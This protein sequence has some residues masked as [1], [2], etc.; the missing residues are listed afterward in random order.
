MAAGLAQ[1]ATESLLSLW[2][3]LSAEQLTGLVE[4]VQ[5]YIALHLYEAQSIDPEVEAA[6][7]L[8]GLLSKASRE[9]LPVPA[10]CLPP[11]LSSLSPCAS[12]PS[13]PGPLATQ[14]NERSGAIPF[15]L[16]YN[17]AVNSDDFNIV[18]D[19]R[20]WKSSTGHFSFCKYSFI[21]DTASK[22]RIL[23][24]PLPRCRPRLPRNATL[25]RLCCQQLENDKQMYNEFQDA[26]L[27]SWLFNATYPFLLLSVRRSPYLV[28]DTL[29]QVESASIAGSLKKPLKVQ[30]IGEEGVDEGGVTKEFFQ[31]LLRELFDPSYGMF[32]YDNATRLHWFR[33][34]QLD[35]E[36]EFRLVGILVGLAIYN[37]QLLELAFPRLLY[38]KLV[39]EKLLL[40]DVAE[41]FPDIYN[42][43]NKAR[44]LPPS[45]PGSFPAFGMAG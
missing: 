40:K 8:L 37:G 10:A 14:A 18:E 36:Q 11:L 5:Q 6:V 33:P 41:A 12:L 9:A 16:F 1:D 3:S 43:L 32:T 7:K 26:I 22:S 20:R 29:R 34:S 21:Y 27:R 4:T 44:R 38:R 35:M 28:H 45:P 19:Y 13:C 30:F 15:S 23:Q 17:D 31:L 39:G 42:S 2:S 25:R 24:V